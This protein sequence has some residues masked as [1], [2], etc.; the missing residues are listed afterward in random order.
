[1]TGTSGW[2]WSTSC[3]L[4]SAAG[5]MAPRCRR[6]VATAQRQPLGGTSSWSA[7]AMALLGSTPRSCWIRRTVG[8][9]CACCG[10][11]SGLL[12]DVKSMAQQSSG[13][14][15]YDKDHHCILCPPDVRF[16]KRANWVLRNSATSVGSIVN[17]DLMV[18]RLLADGAYGSGSWQPRSSVAKRPHLGCWRWRAWCESGDGGNVRPRHQCLDAR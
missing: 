9:R 12:R 6:R 10:P 15:A 17:A 18:L 1:M 3:R 5:V 16:N 7:G 4:T 14:V 13:R 2:T 11:F 8:R